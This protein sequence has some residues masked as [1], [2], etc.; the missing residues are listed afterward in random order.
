MF[1]QVGCR[2]ISGVA[3]KLR[4]A[5]SRGFTSNHARMLRDGGWGMSTL[6]GQDKTTDKSVLPADKS[7]RS[8]GNTLDPVDNTVRPADK[9]LRPAG[10]T[11]HPSGNTLRPADNTARPADNTVRPA[12]FLTEQ[13]FTAYTRLFSDM[14]KNKDGAISKEELKDGLRDFIGYEAS[15]SELS[16]SMLVLD[17]NKDGKVD[18][19]DFLQHMQA[20]KSETRLEAIRFTFEMWTLIRWIII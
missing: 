7:F 6:L 20:R 14:D 16:E 19:N 12:D 11:L 10:N 13:E 1:S 5:G 8:A 4:F 9:T 15:E 2:L 17:K 3:L 18:I